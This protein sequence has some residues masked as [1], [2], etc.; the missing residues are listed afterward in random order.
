MLSPLYWSKW[1]IY[2]FIFNLLYWLKQC[3]FFLVLICI[4][5][6]AFASGVIDNTGCV[7]AFNKSGVE[8]TGCGYHNGVHDLWKW[9]SLTDDYDA[10]KQSK[11][12]EG[13]LSSNVLICLWVTHIKKII[14]NLPV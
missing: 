4:V 6:T 1:F 8:K 7:D 2:L 9:C 12:C 10:D 5:Q 3:I 13:N 11:Y 14:Q